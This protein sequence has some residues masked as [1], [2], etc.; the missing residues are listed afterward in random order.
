MVT[1]DKSLL[2]AYLQALLCWVDSPWRP[3]I[4]IDPYTKNR[5]KEG[6]KPKVVVQIPGLPGDQLFPK[7]KVIIDLILSHKKKGRRTLLFCQQTNTRDITGR[8]VKI[9][10]GAGL[11]AAVLRAA[12]DKREEWVD[13]Q[14]EQGVDVIITHPKRVETGM[15]L[16]QFPTIIWMGIE[17]SVYTVMQASR[18]SWRIGQE[19][20]VE[21][22]FTGYD[23]TLQ[24]D[25]THLIAAKMAAAARV[26]GDQIANESL[27]ELDE[28]TNSDMV[29]ALASIFAGGKR[30]TESLSDAF[31]SAN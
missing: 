2:G 14:V 5:E 4:V 17:Y 19:E 18:R 10:A 11:K 13:K 12:P 24:H 8:W 22:Y 31:S 20:D 25:A 23:Q 16:L 21:V 6:I 7:E 3:E 15:D 29:S 28:L 9:L 30:A 1:G 26:N 27:A